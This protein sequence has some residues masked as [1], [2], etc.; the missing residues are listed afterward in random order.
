MK[1]I[2]IIKNGVYGKFGRRF[3]VTH[4]SKIRL[5]KKDEIIVTKNPELEDG[6]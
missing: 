6:C 3:R 4:R 5:I 1:P 2:K